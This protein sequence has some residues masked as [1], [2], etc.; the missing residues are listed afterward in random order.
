MYAL[1]LGILY[2]IVGLVEVFGGASFI[3]GDIFS[4]LA[5]VVISVVYLYGI[6]GLWN[7]NYGGLSFLLGGLLLSAAFGILYLLLMGADGLM[8]LLGEAEEFSALDDFRPGIWLFFISLP[9]VYFIG[10]RK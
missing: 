9:A 6:K 7:A 4:G 1:V 5:L 8:Y 2:L 10:K 3:P